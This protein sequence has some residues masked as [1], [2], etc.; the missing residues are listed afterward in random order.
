[1]PSELKSF[2]LS[3]SMRD[4]IYLLSFLAGGGL[5]LYL[6]RDL[7]QG[8][9]MA[10][11]GL[12]FA[13]TTAAGVLGITLYRVQLELRASRHELARKEA[14]INFAREV[15]Q[16]L[17]PRQ[18]PEGTGLEFAGLCLP[19]SGISGDYYDVLRRDDGRIVF[20]IADISGKGISAAILMSNLHAVLHTLTAANFSPEDLC[21]QLNRHLHQVTEGARFATLFYAE[22]DPNSRTLRYINAGHNPP[23]WIRGGTTARLEASGPPLGL[24]LRTPYLA[25]EIALEPGD[26]LVLYS[27]GVTEAGIQKGAE[28]GAERL[29]ALVTARRER[30][31]TEIQQEISRVVRQWAR[32]ELEDDMTLLLVRVTEAGKEV[33]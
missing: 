29:E 18:F 6:G 16:E 25:R 32:N 3:E 15:Q 12:T 21:S 8:S 33:V 14:E 28:F 17:F 4:K 30:P 22:W 23:L 11:W 1:L 2:K 5:L 9:A 24:L 31:L 13:G 20:A 26:L 27:D 10:T 7:L 19:A